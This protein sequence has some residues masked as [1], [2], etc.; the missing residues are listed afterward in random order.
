MM[1]DSDKTGRFWMPTLILGVVAGLA[2]PT[3][4]WEMPVADGSDRGQQDIAAVIFTAQRELE[5]GRPD[6]ALTLIDDALSSD[7]TEGFWRAAL[8]YW[9]GETFERQ[10]RQSDA[11][12]SYHAVIE[13]HLLSEF[14]TLA[15]SR[16]A[17]LLPEEKAR[18]LACGIGVRGVGQPG[19][20]QPGAGK[21]ARSKDERLEIMFLAKA[22]VRGDS[23]ALSW[24]MSMAKEGGSTATRRAAIQS[25][26]WV[27]D[28]KVDEFLI[29]LVPDERD[30][31]VA[32]A[33][34]YAIAGRNSV[35][36]IP[37]LKQIASSSDE[38]SL[39]LLAI[40][41]LMNQRSPEIAPFL[42]SIVDGDAAPGVKVTALQCLQGR[43]EI[44]ASELLDMLDRR[45]EECVRAKAAQVLSLLDASRGLDSRQLQ[46][47]RGLAAGES[48]R[49]V[50]KYEIM[51]ISKIGGDS[52]VH[53]LAE[54]AR[55]TSVPEDRGHILM[56]MFNTGSP[57]VIQSVRDLLANTTLGDADL[58][59]LARGIGALNDSRAFGLIDDVHRA[60]SDPSSQK[61][62]IQATVALA[63]RMNQC[64]QGSDLLVKYSGRT[65]DRDVARS[66]IEGLMQ[67]GC[68]EASRAAR[69][70]LDGQEK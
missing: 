16:L 64:Q 28:P 36:S 30:S 10:S 69:Q 27:R 19:Q 48:D 5:E 56:A 14:G 4:G 68:D 25:L 12:Q 11:I 52:S 24:L 62:A 60:C 21:N 34:L 1:L 31:R 39:R 2:L 26:A 44:R 38:E 42:K 70:L 22:S 57:A 53:V 50:W 59:T 54:L 65:M 46:R 37:V 63:L 40:H 6:G 20:G 51:A 23:E 58:R 13:K 43:L 8:L 18:E 66:I 47:I 55:E 15:A 3:L 33:A 32:Q 67:L 9:Q 49:A 7:E 45:E 41:A 17:V 29:H 35:S 61:A